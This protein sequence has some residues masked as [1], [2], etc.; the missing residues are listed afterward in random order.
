M[1]TNALILIVLLLF[2]AL[3]AFSQTIPPFEARTIASAYIRQLGGKNTASS[4]KEITLPSTAKKR[5]G[6][7]ESMSAFYIFTDTAANSPF[8]IV[9]ADRRM[10]EVLAYG[11]RGNWD[12][13]PFPPA[14]QEL[15][16][17]YEEQYCQLQILSPS[18]PRKLPATDIQEVDPMIPTVWGQDC[19]FNNLCPSGCP[20]GCVA[21]AMAQV[22]KYHQYPQ[23]GHDAFS[24][25]S[26][27]RK[28]R[29]SYDFASAIFD[30]D[31]MEYVYPS[32]SAPSDASCDAVAQ[33][34]YACGVSVGM[35]YDYSGSGA[36]MSDIPYAL[37]HFF[38]YN[39]NIS[40]CDR[41]CYEADEWYEMLLTELT[42]GRPV[43]YGGFDSRNGGHAFVVDGYS[44]KEHK[45]HVNWGWNGS[46]D[47]YYELDAL[48][49]NTYK[50]ASYQSMII[51][52]SPQL[53]GI[54][55]DV[56]YADKFSVTGSIDEGQNVIFKISDV[57]CYSSQS[58]YAV[59]DAKFNGKI[60]I[61]IFDKDFHFLESVAASTAEGLNNFYGYTKL[62]YNVKIERELFPGNGQ[63]YFAPYAQSDSS[64]MPTRIR[65]SGA[66]TDGIQITIDDEGISSNNDTE[67]ET[68]LTEWNEDFETVTIPSG[69][70]QEIILGSAKW[71]SR[72][73]LT[74]SESKPQAAHGNGYVYLEFAKGTSDL[75]NS[76][77]VTRL[78]TDYI[79]LN[80]DY[81][82]DL[83]LQY[84]KYATMPESNDILNIYYE[85][86]EGWHLI[87]ELPVTNKG[88]W[89][90]TT[91]Q[92]PE[93]NY[94]RLAFEGCPSRGTFLFL[95]DL[96]IS[97]RII[98]TCID[99]NNPLA[100]TC[101]AK[102]RI[103]NISGCLVGESS[104]YSGINTSAL[105][106][107]I[108]AVRYPSGLIRK[109]KIN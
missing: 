99:D 37:I 93:A 40:Y 34:A 66:E 81:F 71:N 85:D 61:G 96:R 46:F 67:D 12:S 5:A 104:A 13:G 1:R 7:A 65:T 77:S 8:V 90:K 86:G 53:T 95:D 60:G 48:D 50:Y 14:L 41:T 23:T 72:F 2:P 3:L 102:Y 92:L 11:H 36:Y 27:T 69:W 88:D 55:R 73:V 45:F 6:Q 29:C 25:T 70:D 10:K 35:D 91:I 43:I 105:P 74:A 32:D 101:V 76:N 16:E 18:E 109:I 47:G 19:P 103:Y 107:G 24:Y 52:V 30:W 83:S 59:G 4:L 9:S 87:K 100:G 84:R 62:A 80:N 78:I 22:M 54:H 31:K 42:E 21:M 51:N 26:T 33:L 97:Q 57:Y 64:D 82:Y 106:T 89:K 39:D 44:T 20:S 68:Y 17:S 28:Y 63:Y 15:L 79:P 98:N 75:A 56:F 38:G 49:P 94:I 58:S 108:Y